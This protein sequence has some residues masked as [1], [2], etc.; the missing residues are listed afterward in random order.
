MLGIEAWICVVRMNAS[1][2]MSMMCGGAWRAQGAQA[3]DSS[4]RVQKTVRLPGGGA[5]RVRP[6][7]TLTLWLGVAHLPRC[8]SDLRYRLTT[9]TAVIKAP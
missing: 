9:I 1:Q 7:R 2:D 3:V 6:R 5:A 4:G 8:A